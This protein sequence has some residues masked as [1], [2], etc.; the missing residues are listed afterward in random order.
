MPSNPEP[1]EL[2]NYQRSSCMMSNLE[3]ILL[4]YLQEWSWSVPQPLVSIDIKNLNKL[5]LQS[6]LTFTV[7]TY[8]SLSHLSLYPLSGLEN[9]TLLWKRLAMCSSRYQVSVC[10]P[11]EHTSAQSFFL[12]CGKKTPYCRTSK[13][14]TWHFSREILSSPTGSW[15]W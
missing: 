15:S 12:S 6:C 13:W 8:L 4:S 3:Q 11:A 5:Y 7:H 10:I 2:Q 1:E 9:W 14:Q